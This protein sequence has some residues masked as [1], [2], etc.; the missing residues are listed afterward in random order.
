V[1]ARILDIM[2]LARRRNPAA[3][4][5]SQP[6]V[7]TDHFAFAPDDGGVM[8]GAT[9]YIDGTYLQ[10]NPDWH[11]PDSTWKAQQILKILHRNQIVPATVYDVGCGAGEVLRLLQQNL[12]PGCELWGSDVS[13]QALELCHARANDKLHFALWEDRPRAAKFCDLVIAIDVL[14]HVEDYRGFLRRIKAQGEYK[15]VHIPLDISVQ[16]VLR[17]NSMVNRRKV[18]AHLHYFSKRTAM[19]ALADLGYEIVDWFYTPRTIDIPDHAGGK[20]LRLPRKILFAIHP[21]FAVN[22]LGGFSLMVLAK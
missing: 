8:P 11:V 21:D 2:T 3:R 1:R 10:Q 15:L 7:A 17:E 16:H 14:A 18:H 13:P 9:D 5:G 12:A 22:L 19:F 4:K 6:P 20:L